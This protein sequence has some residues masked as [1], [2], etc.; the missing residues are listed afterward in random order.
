MSTVAW[1][2]RPSRNDE[3]QKILSIGGVMD[4]FQNRAALW[5][6][7]HLTATKLA[8]TFFCS[9]L[10]AISSLQAMADQSNAPHQVRTL[11]ITVLVT[12][13]AGNPLEGDGEW[14]YSA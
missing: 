6:V 13:L 11:K 3:M 14:G 1:P 9:A 10:L 5:R 12:N 7:V 2:Y 8:V 4:K